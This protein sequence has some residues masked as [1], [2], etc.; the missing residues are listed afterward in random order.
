MAYDLRP[1][2]RAARCGIDVFHSSQ[3]R[4]ILG[5]GMRIVGTAEHACRTAAG[6]YGFTPVLAGP[7]DAALYG[8]LRQHP[9]DPVVQW[10][11]NDGGHY[12]SNR[13]GFLRAYV[14]PRAQ[15][16][17][18]FCVVQWLMESVPQPR[19]GSIP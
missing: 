13:T 19:G 7:G 2:L 17:F 11:G 14:L 3:D 15:S 6:Q 12:G 10:S 16:D 4:L 18:R 9:W 8:K 5:L 1:A